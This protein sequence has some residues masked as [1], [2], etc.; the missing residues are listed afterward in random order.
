MDI[1]EEILLLAVCL[2]VAYK[3]IK[4]YWPIYEQRKNFTPLQMLGKH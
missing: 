2:F 4:R 1:L 3:L